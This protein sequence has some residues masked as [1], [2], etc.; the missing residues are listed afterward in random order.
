MK[1]TSV[2]GLQFVIKSG[3]MQHFKYT[4]KACILLYTLKKVGHFLETFF[5]LIILNDTLLYCLGLDL[6]II[7]ASIQVTFG[8]FY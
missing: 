7:D 2:T 3:M 1:L 5:I 8:I 6:I 4:M